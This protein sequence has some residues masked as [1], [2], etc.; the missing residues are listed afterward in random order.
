MRRAGFRRHRFPEL[1]ATA[2]SRPGRM[3]HRWL[4]LL[5]LLATAAPAAA[6]VAPVQAPPPDDAARMIRLG[7]T[8]LPPLVA[9]D[10]RL[11]SLDGVLLTRMRFDDWVD[12]F[13]TRVALSAAAGRDSLRAER[14]FARTPAAWAANPPRRR[15]RGHPSPLPPRARTTVLFRRG[16]ARFIASAATGR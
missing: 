13:A 6:Q 16:R 11:P 8:R 14:G 3:L 4:F 7:L 9:V 12:G 5:A 10:F 1:S 15:K 2:R